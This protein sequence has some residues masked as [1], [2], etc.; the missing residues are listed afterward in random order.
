MKRCYENR[1]EHSARTSSLRDETRNKHSHASHHSSLNWQLLN[2]R[3][4]RRLLHYYYYYYY[5]HFMTLC[6]GLPRWVSTRRIN[7]SGFCW[8]R[9]DGVAVASAEPYASYLHFATEDNQSVRFLRAGCLSWHPTKSI[10]ALKHWFNT[11][12]E[13][14]HNINCRW[15]LWIIVTKYTEVDARCMVN[16]PRLSVKH[17]PSQVFSMHSIVLSIHPLLTTATTDM[18]WQNFSSPEFRTKFQIPDCI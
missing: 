16:W 4:L 8:S 17:R 2:S 10:K 13:F 6:P 7:H 11:W 14:R 18:Q 9:H 1:S 15:Q 5:N 3:W 12:A